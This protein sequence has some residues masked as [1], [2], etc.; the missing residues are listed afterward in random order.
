MLVDHDA[1]LLHKQRWTQLLTDTEAALE[2][3]D[4]ILER[5]RSAVDVYAVS[6]LFWA[7]QKMDA[8]VLDGWSN[9]KRFYLKE[10]EKDSFKQAFTNNK[11]SC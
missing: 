3:R 7:T 2:N 5:G 4:S 11:V 10:S 9:I 1:H 8:H 6:I